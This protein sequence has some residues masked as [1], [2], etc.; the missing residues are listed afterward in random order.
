MSLSRIFD[1]GPGYDGACSG[2]M[3]FH[4][5]AGVG[6]LAG[7]FHALALQLREPPH[8]YVDPMGKGRVNGRLG[9][10]GLTPRSPAVGSTILG[11]DLRRSYPGKRSDSETPPIER[12]SQNTGN[13]RLDSGRSIAVHPVD[14][15]PD[16]VNSHKYLAM[17]GR[18]Q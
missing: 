15:P 17:T 1:L 8:T 16:S 14:P 9:R 7:E 12:S 5:F 11:F 13:D 6:T 3:L 10:N 18:T 4:P 2:A